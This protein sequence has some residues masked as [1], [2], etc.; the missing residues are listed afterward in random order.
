MPCKPGS[1]FVN[2]GKDCLNDCRFCVKRFGSFFGYSLNV[3]YTPETLGNIEKELERIANLYK[4]PKE[5]VICGTGEPFLHYD[6]I[7]KV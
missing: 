1:I 6:D 2:F 3:D 7:L 4:N 5:I